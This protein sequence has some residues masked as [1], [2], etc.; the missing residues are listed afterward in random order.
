MCRAARIYGYF[1]PGKT[2]CPLISQRLLAQASYTD[3][4]VV[5]HV[6]SGS[7]P[8]Q[9]RNYLE[10]LTL[11]LQDDSVC[12]T[13]N[14]SSF[15]HA[16]IISQSLVEESEMK[17]NVENVFNTLCIWWVAFYLL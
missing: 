1:V 16:T 2:W 14:V 3:L 10:D 7:D 12:L 9:L 13:S 8:V 5:G 4:M 11:T 6:I 17:I 15:L